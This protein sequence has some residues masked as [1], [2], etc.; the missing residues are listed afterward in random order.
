MDAYIKGIYTPSVLSYLERQGLMFEIQEG[1][2]ELIQRGAECFDFL[3][4]NYYQSQCVKWPSPP[5]QTEQ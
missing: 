4:I 1:D 5:L 3:G 2:M